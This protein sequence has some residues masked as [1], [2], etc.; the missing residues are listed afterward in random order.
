MPAPAQNKS[1]GTLTFQNSVPARGWLQNLSFRSGLPPILGGVFLSEP[2]P[3]EDGAGV[4]LLHFQAGN[5]AALGW[6]LPSVPPSDK[7]DRPW[8]C[9]VFY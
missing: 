6:L 2:Q 4:L 1:K 3:V 7:G 5:P 9:F 8:F